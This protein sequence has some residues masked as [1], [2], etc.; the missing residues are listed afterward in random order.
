MEGWANIWGGVA[1]DNPV[2]RK[3]T[4]YDTTRNDTQTYAR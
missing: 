2:T 3:S 1:K 4:S